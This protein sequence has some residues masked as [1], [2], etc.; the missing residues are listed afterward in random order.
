M[1]SSQNAEKNKN[2]CGIFFNILLTY[3]LNRVEKYFIRPFR[4]V[5]DILPR[6]KMHEVMFRKDITGGKATQ[7]GVENPMSAG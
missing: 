2:H 5:G 7:S 4:S 1:L 6:N 3:S